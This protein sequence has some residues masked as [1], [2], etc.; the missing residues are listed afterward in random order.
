MH[1]HTPSAHDRHRKHLEELL[2]IHRR[3]AQRLEK[4]RAQHGILTPTALSN[5]LDHE[6]A[7][8]ARVKAELAKHDPPQETDIPLVSQVLTDERQASKDVELPPPRPQPLQ[9][10]RAPLA[11]T[12]SYQLERVFHVT[13]ARAVRW[14]GAGGIA[15]ALLV[16][17]LI[18]AAVQASRHGPGANIRPVGGTFTATITIT[19]D[20]LLF[21]QQH[22]DARVGD[23]VGVVL[24]NTSAQTHNWV[25]VDGDA[26]VVERVVAQGALAGADHEFVP[27]DAAVVEYIG[28]IQP[29]ER[30]Q[31]VVIAATP[32]TYT[33]VCT[34]PGHYQA[35]MFGELVVQQ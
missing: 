8:I 7:A 3:N 18:I 34:M 25:L 23:I 1:E 20:T 35:G 5:A 26:R 11:R 29:N 19:N 12:R 33:F 17:V 13:R 21:D 24:S 15:F 2:Y 28:R 22:V 9:T 10:A 4:Q 16:A 27:D 31:T 6:Y 30:G 14:W 32:G